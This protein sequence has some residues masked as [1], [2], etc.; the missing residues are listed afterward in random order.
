MMHGPT[1]NKPGLTH[2]A[3]DSSGRPTHAPLDTTKIRRHGRAIECRRRTTAAP[4]RYRDV[5]RAKQEIRS[6]AAVI[7]EFIAL[8]PGEADAHSL[9][10]HLAHATNDELQKLG[11]YRTL[12]LFSPDSA[13]CAK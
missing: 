12:F 13:C 1:R 7:D 2:F 10:S 3:G 4:E 11:S 6:S 9:F 8:M 5:L